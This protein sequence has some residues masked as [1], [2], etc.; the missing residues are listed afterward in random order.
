[1][2]HML[3]WMDDDLNERRRR[4]LYR[5]RRRLQS[6]QGVRVV[7]RG[8]EYLNF[9]SNDYLALAADPRLARA[10]ARAAR[11]YGAGAGASPLV[12]GLTPPVRRLERVL[13]DWEST[14]AA[15][16]FSSGFAANLAVVSTLAGRGDA[17]FSDARNHASLIDGCRLSRAR[18]HVYR[19]ADLNH[20]AD[21]LRSE[22]TARRRLIVSDS[23]FSMD[24]DFAPL[25]GLLELAERFDAL[26]V[27]DEAHATGVLGEHGRG[28]TEL[29]RVSRTER[30][31]K[32]GTLSKARGAQ[33]GFVCGSRRLIAW[34]VNHARPYIFSTALAPPAAAAAARAVEIVRTEPEARQHLHQLA[35]RVRDGLRDLGFDGNGSRCQIVPLVVGAPRAA[36]RLSRALEKVGLLV[37]AIRPPSVPEGAARLRISLTA[38]HS[39]EDVE[40]LLAALQ[41]AGLKSGEV[42]SRYRM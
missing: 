8:R 40:R 38:G 27:L 17:I 33:G 37:P 11:R 36:L 18:I 19:H 13:A 39:G 12:S 4:G 41:R 1:V 29:L 30:L 6:A 21:L 25:P 9:S 26:L 3:A 14:E 15:L 5:T 35:E 28:L 31:I 7:L 20:L 23:V 42:G 2:T 10:A 24:G 22:T 32:V 16:V 34:L